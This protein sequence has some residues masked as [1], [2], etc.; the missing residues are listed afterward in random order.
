MYGDD[1]SVLY[2][3]RAAVRLKFETQE[4]RENAVLDCAKALDLNPKYLKARLRR[5]QTYEALEKLEDALEDYQEALK[6]DPGNR[7][8]FEASR[9]LPD[10]IKEKNEKLKE[11]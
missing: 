5:A 3:N 11:E 6:Q 10:A 9:R 7:E 4:E 1:R 2:A 8:A